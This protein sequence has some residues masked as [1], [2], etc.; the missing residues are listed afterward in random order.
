MEMKNDPTYFVVLACS[1][2]EEG[3]TGHLVS[4]KEIPNRQCP[5]QIHSTKQVFIVDFIVRNISDMVVLVSSLIKML[6]L[7]PPLNQP[8]LLLFL[9]TFIV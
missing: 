5:L 3:D 1:K 6:I 4:D 7:F 2:L 9:E 8:L